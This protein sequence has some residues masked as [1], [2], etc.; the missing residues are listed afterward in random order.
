MSVPPDFAPWTPKCSQTTQGLSKRCRDLID[1]TATH[2][3]KR[4]RVETASR[5]QQR[6]AMGDTL[7][8]ISQSH[9]RRCFTN[10]SCVARCLTTSS[11]LYSFK[12][13]RLL[14]PLEHLLLQG[15]PLSTEVPDS[16]TAQATRSLAGE[17][18]ALPCLA[19][20]VWAIYISRGFP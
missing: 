4:A 16:F 15:Y 9:A 5:T 18:I 2:L 3:C 17:G 11:Q 1:C 10:E 7:L 19:T 20:L 12:H 13:D 14:E 8:D 6:Q